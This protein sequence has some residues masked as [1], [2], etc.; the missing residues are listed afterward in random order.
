MNL[1][2]N[3]SIDATIICR[4]TLTNSANYICFCR[5][6]VHVP[7][8]QL[9]ATCRSPI[10]ASIRVHGGSSPSPIVIAVTITAASRT[11]LVPVAVGS[12]V[13]GFEGR[14]SEGVK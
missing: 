2:R 5:K 8:G 3:V 7:T 13:V 12:L 6:G 9:L 11:H 1:S 10:V 4:G 14:C